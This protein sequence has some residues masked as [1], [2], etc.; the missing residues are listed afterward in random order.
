MSPLAQLGALV[1]KELRLLGA[2][3]G[4]LA[5]L[6]LLPVL[7]L[8]VMS[9]ALQGLYARGQRPVVVAVDRDRGPIAARVI[10]RLA[11]SGDLAV[12]RIGDPKRAEV[13]VREHQAVAALVFPADFSL[14]ARSGVKPAELEL[15]ADPATG[16]Q[17]LAPVAVAVEATAAQ[18]VAEAVLPDAL[19]RRVRDYAQTLA[20]PLTILPLAAR[21]REVRT[22]GVSLR[23]RSTAD[24]AAVLP[25]AKP[26]SAQQNVPAWT[27]F[28][29]FFVVNVLALSL[30]RERQDN[31][32]MRLQAT[33]APVW[34]LLLG[35]LLPFYLVNLLQAALLFAVG[36]GVL[37]LALGAHPLALVPVT[38]ATA[39]VATNLGLLIATWF[40]TPEQLG[41]TASILSVLLAA[42]GGLLIP[43]YVMPD[44]MRRL[45]VFTPQHWALT[46]YQDVLLRGGGLGEVLPE[47]GILGAFALG[48]FA[49]AV[50]RWRQVLAR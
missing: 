40:E 23:E 41:G 38:L 29:I 3:R 22:G 47:V 13:A 37:H 18:T 2:D 26:D 35:K 49:L 50:V 12:E 44:F 33:G 17:L 4:A 46:G 6:F 7:F 42:L 30:V 36:I 32:L 45:A 39:A 10:D 48:F 21:L 15:V 16:R 31:I 34:V 9:L 20:D 11:Q 27:I 43:I 5:T 19:A 1:V 28:G 8:V 14:R 25:G 24:L